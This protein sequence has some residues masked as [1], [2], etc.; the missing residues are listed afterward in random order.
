MPLAHGEKLGSGGLRSSQ[1]SDMSKLSH[2]CGGA[3]GACVTHLSLEQEVT[4]LSWQSKRSLNSGGRFQRN[5]L[6][7][8]KTNAA[9]KD[10]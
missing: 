1:R 3:A 9:V 4:E 7:H 10:E 5:G 6:H 8:D 2:S